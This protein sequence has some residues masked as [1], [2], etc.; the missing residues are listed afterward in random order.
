M[1]ETSTEST[2]ST[3]TS[4]SPSVNS[5]EL[6]GGI[7]LASLQL[8]IDATLTSEIE[9]TYDLIR[10][11]DNEENLIVYLQTSQ[12]ALNVN[13]IIK[14]GDTL[15]CIA[16][17]KGFERIVKHFVENNAADVNLCRSINST[18]TS[19]STI[20][21]TITISA[22]RQSRLV[23]VAGTPS[24]SKNA[25]RGDSPLSICVKYGYEAI[26]V[27]LIDRGADICGYDSGQLDQPQML[28]HNIY[29]DFE[30][31]PLQ[32]AIRLNRTKI[33]EKMLQSMFE[34]DDM[35]T[36]EWVFAKR[37]DILRQVLMTENLDTIKVILPNIIENRR[38]DGEMLIH[39]LNY[40][41]MKSKIQERKDKVNQIL[42]T[43]MEIGTTEDENHKV[44]FEIYNLDIF[45]R[46][47]LATLK[48]LF[49]AVSS[50]DSRTNILSYRTSLFFFVMKY[51]KAIVNF[52]QFYPDL[53]TTFDF[54]YTKLK[55]T[56]ENVLKLV[57]YFITFYDTLITMN[58]IHLTSS[59][60]TQLLRLEHIKKLDILGEFLIQRSLTP[61]DLK[62]I[63]RLKVKECM[64]TY[65][66]YTITNSLP[67]LDENCK[68]FLYFI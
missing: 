53:D 28:G 68:E 67:I 46:G 18:S 15:L 38:I 7:D 23:S 62:E 61:L 43:V 30:R 6:V 21:P 8:N 37:Y 22:R 59:N 49:N 44:K 65:N 54:F 26:A 52:E 60:V 64:H 39:I 58:H 3:S 2:S 16:C 50:D 36:I 56:G 31:S 63:S 66:L 42:E 20:T 10:R 25:Q 17:N 12:K 33:V 11:N 29:S 14:N 19:F 40:L 45:V 9:R 57:E 41:L 27:Y 51:Q 55:E 35:R 48:A 13:E 1:T 34:R 47:F 32:D 5:G 4:P 24:A